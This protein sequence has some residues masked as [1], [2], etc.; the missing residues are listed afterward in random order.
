MHVKA[1]LYTQSGG[2]K[3]H[4]TI[5]TCQ[6]G[7]VRIAQSAHVRL[8]IQRNVATKNEGSLGLL[9]RTNLIKHC[10]NVFR[11]YKVVK[12]IGTT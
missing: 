4:I 7:R 10:F 1:S 3:L 8:L 9:L 5:C 12:Q 6:Q 2:R 11:H